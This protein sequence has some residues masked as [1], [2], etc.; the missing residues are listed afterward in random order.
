M[1]GSEEGLPTP[2][3]M[4][5]FRLLA[6]AKRDA[7][8]EWIEASLFE[9]SSFGTTRKAL[10]FAHHH[11][12]HEALAE[13]CT[14]KLPRGAWI[15]VTGHTPRAERDAL[16]RRFQTDAQCRFAL[17]ALTACGVGLNLACADTAV[18][19]ELCWSPSTMEQAEARIHRIGQAASHV[20]VYYLTAGEGRESP[21]SAM[22]GALVKKSQRAAKVVDGTEEP[23]CLSRA[24]VHHTPRREAA[25][26]LAVGEEADEAAGGEAASDE[27]EEDLADIDDGV[28]RYKPV[29][30]M[31]RPREGANAEHAEA[32]SR[33]RID[34][35]EGSSGSGASAGSSSTHAAVRA[36][37]GGSAADPLC[38]SDSED[39]AGAPPA[40]PRSNKTTGRR[41][42]IEIDSD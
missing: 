29:A 19:T 4:R 11:S 5:M 9:D 2:E 18:F 32:S 14:A 1:G 25:A 6:D 37:G 20:N 24:A 15:Q 10:V 13:L 26:A 31:R 21:D 23:N 33:R 27:Q 28:T 36:G 41:V 12:V 38:L 7:V 22:F 3:L 17:L 39:E 34:F 30:G 8:K 42:V 40:A 35:G 16:L